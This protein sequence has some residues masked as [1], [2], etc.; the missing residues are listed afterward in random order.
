M[1]IQGS[2]SEGISHH[3]P[4]MPE[5]RTPAVGIWA[6]D[7]SATINFFTRPQRTDYGAVTF[8]ELNGLTRVR[9]N[10]DRRIGTNSLST[11]GL[12]RH[13]MLQHALTCTSI[14]NINDGKEM[15]LIPDGEFVMG[16]EGSAQKVYLDGYYIDRYPVTNS[17]YSKF[18]HATQ[19]LPPIHWIN[20][21]IPRGKEKHPVI[22][23]SWSDAI[24]YAQWAGCRLPTEAEWE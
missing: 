2:A 7:Q 6:K 12:A 4:L 16:E 24:V 19:Y 9:A 17:D 22:N 5:M 18:V 1:T 13:I 20:G 23:V 3:T 10:P 8:S 14:T 21:A 11:P 15:I